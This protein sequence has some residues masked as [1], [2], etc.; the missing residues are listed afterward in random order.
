MT[1]WD[2]FAS[3][4]PEIAARGRGLIERSGTGEAL[5]ATVH[6]DAPPR[7]NPIYVEIV[8]GRLLA[9][10]VSAPRWRS[11]AGPPRR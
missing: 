1:T 10:P 6:G 3:G 5:L 9:A 2:D 4:A 8:D 7:I 11:P